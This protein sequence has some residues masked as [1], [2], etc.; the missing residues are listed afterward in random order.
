MTVPRSVL[1]TVGPAPATTAN[2][3]LSAQLAA[4]P[5]YWTGLS[6]RHTADLL[7]AYVM[8]DALLTCGAVVAAS[9]AQV[10][11]RPRLTVAIVHPH[12]AV[13]TVIVIVAVWVLT[14]VEL[15]LYRSRPTIGLLDECLLLARAVGITVVVSSA[16]AFFLAP[17]LSAPNRAF[18]LIVGALNFTAVAALH[19]TTRLARRALRH[20]G[21]T[22]RRVAIVGQDAPA[23]ELARRLQ[24]H[25]PSSM[26]FRGFITVPVAGEPGTDA[27]PVLGNVESIAAVINEHR[28][29]ALYLA[30]PAARRELTARLSYELQR[31]HVD[32]YLVPDL[33]NVFTLQEDVT[34][35]GGLPV[36]TVRAPALSDSAR[37]IKRVGDVLLTLVAFVVLLPLIVAVAVAVRL[38]SPGPIL[39]RQTRVGEGGRLFQMY[40]FR[41]MAHQAAILGVGAA[42]LPKQRNDPRVTRV[43]AII[44]RCSLDELPQMINVLKG[45]MSLIGPRPELPGIVARYEPW[46]Y[47]RQAVPPGVTGWWQV[48]GRGDLPLHLN[49][50]LDLY[51]IRHYS[52]L[53]DLRILLRTIKAVFTT[54]GSF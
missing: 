37:I 51:Y 53:L 21:H 46:Q 24:E 45:E 42:T 2:S 8:L 18:Y 10:R 20:R 39:F 52:V 47:A 7:T 32:V 19:A 29:D 12:V 22:V 14:C 44:R 16:V 4:P 13:S 3:L 23:R 49:T 17:S 26:L 41:S 43:G 30:L 9:M 38:D 15:N 48:N 50:Q 11:L 27:M 33:G 6:S 25:T 35:L 54:R 36:I 40:K 34:T 28:L 5:G 31:Y 1:T